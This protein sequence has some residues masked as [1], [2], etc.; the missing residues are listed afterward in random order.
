LGISITDSAG[1][2]AQL[3]ADPFTITISSSGGGNSA[4]FFYPN[5]DNLADVDATF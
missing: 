5:G 3:A 2:T 4:Q 1:N